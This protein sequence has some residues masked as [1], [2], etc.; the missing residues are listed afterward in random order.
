VLAPPKPPSDELELLIKEAR[1]RQVRRRR[2]LGAA[3][4][5]IAAAL[6]LG[7][8]ALVGGFNRQLNSGTSPSGGVP[9]CRT[10]Q[11]SVSFPMLIGVMSR[12]RIIL[13]V[14]TNK[15]GTPCSLPLHP[16]VARITW[17]GTVLPTRQERGKGIVY[18]SW[19]PLR[20][21]RVLKP[22]GRAAI[23]GEWRNWCGRPHS[24]RPMMT[25]HLRFDSE[26]RIA[27]PIGPAAFCA[28]PGAP[29]TIR[30]SQPLLVR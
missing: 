15:S 28:S 8:Y 22:G 17:H 19:E 9:H 18:G 25:V 5:A 7:V 14:M 11:I 27:F 12:G 16:P 26:F 1:A 2:L 23:S 24:Y 10:S 20:V 6:G 30:V 13:F 4:V 3:S 21:I 29:S